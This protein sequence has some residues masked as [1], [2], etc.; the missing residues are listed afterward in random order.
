MISVTPE[1]T[2]VIP[3]RN[4]WPLLEVAM[5]SVLAQEDVELELVVVD[6]GSTDETLCRLDVHADSR[7]RIIRHESAEGVA[8]ARNDGI[9]A[10][11]TPWVA[12]LDDDDAWAPTKVRR[13][14]DA[15][16]RGGRFSYTGVVRVDDDFRVTAVQRAARPET[17]RRDLSRQNV[18]DGPSSLMVA[19]ALLREL[20]GFDEH[21]SILADWEL[22]LRLAATA[23]PAA[24]DEPLVAYQL[25]AANMHVTRARE[26]LAELERLKRKHPDLHVDD[27]WYLHWVAVALRRSG[28]TAQALRLMLQVAVRKRDPVDSTRALIY[29][30]RS[31]A[32]RRVSRRSGV[33]SS[34]ATSAPWLETLCV[35][36]RSARDRP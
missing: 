30:L 5:R 22:Y 23:K 15:L 17:V 20:G 36:W 27:I 16:A 3:T 33:S 14:L 28:H 18:I 31:A 34:D 9:A 4:R 25:H 7:L 26:L 29:G 2:V 8:R 19:T 13:Q 11:R 6:D 35:Q 10:A 21:F 12:F 24:V 32:A 1:V